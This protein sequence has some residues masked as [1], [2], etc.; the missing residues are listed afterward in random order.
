MTDPGS[1]QTGLD[2][3]V[4]FILKY[5]VTL[6][7]LAALTVGLLEAYKK[8]FNT[9]ALFHQKALMRWLAEEAPTQPAGISM[10]SSLKPGGHYGVAPAAK[11]GHAAKSTPYDAS[12][13]YAEML[14]LTTGV[15]IGSTTSPGSGDSN[16]ITRNVSFALFELELAKMMSQIQEA[17][18][19][20][21]NNPTRYEQW[22]SFVTR[23]SDEDDV[24]LWVDAMTSGQPLSANPSSKQFTTTR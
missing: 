19:A 3:I 15:R 1:I 18:D 8:L 13:A 22:F 10:L 2:S 11:T 9:L 12:T 6:A 17:A 24:R 16:S 14:H 4:N 20:A 7:A 23:G 5:A 21:L